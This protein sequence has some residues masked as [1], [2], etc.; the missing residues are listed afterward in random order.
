MS[1]NR[2]WSLRKADPSLVLQL[3]RELKVHPVVARVLIARGITDGAV[4]RDYLSPRLA[5]LIPPTTMAG[6]EQATERV[7]GAVLRGELIGVFGDYDVDGISSSVLIADYLR[8]VGAKVT[9]RVAKR[10]EGYGLGVPQA[11]EMVSRG[12][13]LLVL[14]DC[15]TSDHAAVAAATGEGA[16]VV[17]VDHHQVTESGWPGLVLVNP[18]RPDCGFPF[19]GLTS[20]GLA[21]YLVASLRR[22]LERNDRDAPDP[23]ESLD[24]VALG[25]VADVAPLEAENRILVSRGLAQLG[26]TRRPGLRELMRLAN[27]SGRHPTSDQVGWRLGPRLNAPGRLGDA[28][29]SFDCL[30]QRDTGKGILSARRCDALNEQRKSIQARVEAEAVA[31][32]E[33]QVRQGHS[34][35]L[36]VGRGWH[37]GVI[38]IV[39]ARLVSHTGR[40]AAA[41]ALEDV[42]E[43][44]GSARSVP[45]VDLVQ[46]LR[47]CAEHMVRFGGHAAAAGFSVRS[48][49]IEALHRM[50]DEQTRPRLAQAPERQLWVDS[51]IELSR[52]DNGLCQDLLRLGPHGSG[53]PEPVFAASNVSVEDA[54]PLGGTQHLRL[55]VRQGQAGLEAVGFGLGAWLDRLPERLDIAFVPEYDDFLGPR[56]RLRLIDIRPVEEGWGPAQ[57]EVEP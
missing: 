19:K 1:E 9:V 41:I 36:A 3:H 20:V 34:F 44:R 46:L 16:D 47:P 30:W 10:D 22:F 51:V 27:I 43:A 26:I 23:R 24:L 4:A 5:N 42:P 7:G 14:T 35:I 45:D 31:Q 28:T 25:T 52:I 11:L 40:P 29:V 55:R 57:Q 37:P 50:L 48:D 33:E 32:A 38:G 56:L 2:R 15:G 21:F 13:T 53:N 17:A 6:L 49:R 8:R 12:C 54:R 18:H 39:A